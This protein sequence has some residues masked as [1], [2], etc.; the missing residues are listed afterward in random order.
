MIATTTKAAAIHRRRVNADHT[1]PAI[2]S[3]KASRSATVSRPRR[4]RLS[5]GLL[6]WTGQ[7]TA[8]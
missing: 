2:G 6:Q 3:P 8:V 7:G 5:N 4:G 1:K